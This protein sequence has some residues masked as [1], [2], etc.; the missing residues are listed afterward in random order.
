MEKIE[1]PCPLCSPDNPVPHKILK[2]TKEALLQC[3]ECGSVHKEKKPKNVLVRVILSK[4]EKSIHTRAMLAGMIRKG[5]ELVIDDEATG[6]AALAQVTSVEVGDKRMDKGLAEDIKTI[7]ARAID[8]VIVK[9]A[10][11]HREITE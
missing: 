8:E 2:G 3:E 11:S 9:I 10:V 1:I 5:D 6:E 4:G 7:W